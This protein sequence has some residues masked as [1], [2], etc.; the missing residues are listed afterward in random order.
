MELTMENIS[1]ATMLCITFPCCGPV[2]GMAL[3][4]A[5]ILYL[6]NL[7]VTHASRM[8]A[9]SRGEFHGEL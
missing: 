9:I 6:H 5:A 8:L 1:N 2:D 4:R 3:T 7:D